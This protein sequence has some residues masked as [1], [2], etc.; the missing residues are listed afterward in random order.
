[1]KNS[2][3]WRFSN[4]IYR[5]EGVSEILLHVQDKFSIDV[6][7]ILFVAWLAS[8]NRS[9]TAS[10][11]QDAQKLV[12]L[13]R[14]KVIVPVRNIRRSVKDFSGTDY[15]YEDVK[16][17]EIDT[18]KEELKILYNNYIALSSEQKSELKLDLLE[19]NLHVLNEIHFF[20]EDKI[21]LTQVKK[22]L[23]IAMG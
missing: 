8:V 16:K 20:D 4:N 6:N 3:L 1:M 23:A 13:W 14:T 7:M 2:P 15:L 10:D 9:L 12:S 21:V 11:I 17:L 18:E 5:K 22:I 19:S